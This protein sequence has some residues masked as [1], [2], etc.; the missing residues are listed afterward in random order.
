MI[1]LFKLL[2]AQTCSPLVGGAWSRSCI[3]WVEEGAGPGVGGLVCPSGMPQT[4]TCGREPRGLPCWGLD[5]STCGR[6]L[7]G[8]TW[9]DSR[10]PGGL[11]R[12]T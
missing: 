9:S 6:G 4:L 12:E 2:S 10:G 11:G 8:W 7:R 5:R 1:F 3:L